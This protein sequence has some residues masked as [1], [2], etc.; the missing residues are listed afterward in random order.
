VIM[1]LFTTL[2]SLGVGVILVERVWGSVVLQVFSKELDAYFLHV[3]RHRKRVVE[4][5]E[6]WV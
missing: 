4:K 2:F 1:Y 5:E 6:W 3:G